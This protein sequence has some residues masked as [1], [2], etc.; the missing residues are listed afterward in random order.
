VINLKEEKLLLDE[1]LILHNGIKNILENLV[2]NEHYILYFISPEVKLKARIIND[3]I[4]KYSK[5][6]PEQLYSSLKLLALD[7]NSDEILRNISNELTENILINI[8]AYYSKNRNL[9]L[10]I[11][12]FLLQYTKNNFNNRL[13]FLVNILLADY[14]LQEKNFDLAETHMKHCI[15]YINYNISVNEYETMIVYIICGKYLEKT[16]EMFTS[17]AD[18]YYILAK[19][20][21]EDLNDEISLLSILSLLSYYYHNIEQRE[22]SEEYAFRALSIAKMLNIAE[23]YFNVYK[24]LAIIKSTTG[25][26]RQASDYMK[27]TIEYSKSIDNFSVIENVKLKNSLGYTYFL[28]GDFSS[29][30]EIHFNA[31][32]TLLM[33]PSASE[34]LEEAVKTCDNLSLSFK[35][36]GDFHNAVYFS[37]ATVKIMEDCNFGNRIDIQNLCKQYTDLGITYGLFMND[38]KNALKY[39]KLA[40]LHISNNDHFIKLS[41]ILMLE[42]YIKFASGNIDESYLCFSRASDLLISNGSGNIYVQS[43]LLLYYIA[44]SKIFKVYTNSFT[45]SAKIISENYNLQS[46]FNFYT[47]IFI[48]ERCFK[49]INYDKNNYTLNLIFV[50]SQERRNSLKESKKAN[51]FEIVQNFS[52]KISTIFSEDI[53]Y[54]EAKNMFNKYFLSKGII[55]SKHA[56]ETGISSNAYLHTE[57]SNSKNE[58]LSFFKNLIYDNNLILNSHGRNYDIFNF[59]NDDSIYI[60]SMILYFI[61]DEINSTTYYFAIFNNKSSDWV[62]SNEDAEVGLILVKNLFLKLKTIQ[63]TEKLKNNNFIDYSTGLYNAKYMWNKLD[64][65]LKLYKNMNA[66]FSI[67]VLDLNDFKHINDT[68]GHFSGDEAIKYFSKILKLNIPSP[69]DI[70]RYGGD[71]FVIIFPKLSASEAEEYI[72][73]A[74]N[75]C[76]KCPIILNG[77]QIY[78]DFSYGVGSR[79]NSFENSKALFEHVDK[80]MYNNKLTNKRLNII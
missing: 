25:E 70:I 50:L 12:E 46:H 14:F 67:A 7:F 5:D 62:Y 2:L 74:K 54:E 80:L 65:L 29:S 55:M 9:P 8:Y 37:K 19:N 52:N 31:L 53:L 56:F 60:K 68:Y 64:E 42:S 16:K 79:T 3:L 33:V 66:D 51:D 4:E 26:Y 24:I 49:P 59:T 34:I 69:N 20:I 61:Y 76:S 48:N 1:K 27:S 32:N 11:L 78:L 75:L 28:Q 41:N 21:A 6:I 13:I 45:E 72:L 77:F 35:M 44:F 30:L 17:G 73:K 40:R 63:Y 71:E 15:E 43:L 36:L 38:N 47:D 57:T 22:K 18:N 10:N 23:L 58:I 39:Y